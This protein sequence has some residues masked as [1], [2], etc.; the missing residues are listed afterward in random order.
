MKRRVRASSFPPDRPLALLDSGLLAD[1]PLV[2]PPVGAW[3]MVMG[4]TEWHVVPGFGDV[5]GHGTACA[6]LCRALAPG[7]PLL[8]VAIFDWEPWAPPERLVAA[9]RWVIRRG[10]AVI[11]LSVGLRGL[12]PQSRGDLKVVCAE[13]ARARIRLVAAAPAAA[14]AFDPG[15]LP[16]VVVAEADPSLGCSEI[17]RVKGD[18]WRFRA[19]PLPLPL[20][21]VSQKVDFHGPSL[22]AARV[23]VYVWRQRTRRAGAAPRACPICTSTM[24]PRLG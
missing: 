11:N 12:A 13:A 1:H 19:S 24:L 18:G 3:Q 8:S 16:G 10:A 2:G 20:P 5:L 4:E 21:G 23:S 7:V 22:A 14:D 17:R 6:A 9:L 15:M